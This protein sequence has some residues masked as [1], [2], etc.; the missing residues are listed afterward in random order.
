MKL[1]KKARREEDRTVFVLRCDDRYALCK[2]PERGLLAGLWQ[3]PDVKGKMD[4]EQAL[5]HLQSLG[6]TPK[7]ICLQAEKSHIF[8]HVQWNMRGFY[9]TV[10][11]T[12]DDYLWVDKNALETR[13]ALPTAYRQFWDADF[14]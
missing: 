4:A 9:I 12:A 5:A 13:Y 14:F 2:R 11:R 1:P 6:L 3:F 10:S 7:D 8:T